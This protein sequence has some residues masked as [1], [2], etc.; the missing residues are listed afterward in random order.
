MRLFDFNENK[1][2]DFPEDYHLENGNYMNKCAL[3]GC[4]F[5][6]YKRRCICK[7]CSTA[8]KETKNDNN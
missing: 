4:E 1:D 5:K 3:C 7:L 8:N 2:V 6:G